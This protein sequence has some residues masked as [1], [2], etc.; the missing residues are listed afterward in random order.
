MAGLLHSAC[1]ILP[2]ASLNIALRQR[3]A[4]FFELVY[5]GPVLPII[6]A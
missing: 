3:L 1:F 5:F 4:G 2:F 6:R